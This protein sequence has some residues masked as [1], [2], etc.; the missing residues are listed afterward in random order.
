MDVQHR[1]PLSTVLPLATITC[2][3]MLAMDLYL[4]A[5]PTLQVW[6]VTDVTLVQATVAVFLVGLGL[7]QLAWAEVMARVGPRA[8][9]RFGVLA[10]V[11]SS[12]A[13][14]LAPSIEV[15][16]ALRALQGFAAGAATVVTPS[17]GGERNTSG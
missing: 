2:T 13:A 9:V 12:V 14:A 15:L 5:V 10:L 11:G 8:S 3:S 6:F 17:E 1:P 16:I 7:S 4:P